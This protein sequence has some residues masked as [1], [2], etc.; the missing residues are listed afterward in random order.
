M[1][2]ASVSKTDVRKD[3]RVRLPLS[4]PCRYR[5]V[6]TAIRLQPKIDPPSSSEIARSPRERVRLLVARVGE[7]AVAG[8]CAALLNGTDSYDDPRRPAITWLGGRHAAGLLRRGGFEE[9]GQDYWPRVWAARGLL[10]AWHPSAESAVLAGLRDRGAWR[11]REMAAKVAR[12]R[13]IAAAEPILS[14]LL[15]DPNARVRAAAEAALTESAQS[16]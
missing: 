12:Q 9:R 10:Y 1:A 4:A 5:T 11:V 7:E 13:G 8:L 2:D 15:D 16:P 3:V 6:G 14:R